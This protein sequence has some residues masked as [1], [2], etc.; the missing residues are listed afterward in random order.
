VRRLIGWTA[1]VVGIAAL[2]RA[3]ARKRVHEAP[4]AS[5]PPVDDHADALRRKLDETRATE[6]APPA[7]EEPQPESEPEAPRESLEER[8]AR[9]HAKAQEAIDSMQEPL[10]EP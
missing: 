5:A 9:V 3:L 10:D 2:A 4:T 1:G 6:P 8:R 7:A